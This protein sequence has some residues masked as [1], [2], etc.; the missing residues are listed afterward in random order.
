MENIIASSFADPADVEAFKKWFKIYRDQGM[1]E[2]AATKAAFR[3][4]DNGIGFTGVFCA[5]EAE[6]LCALPP[7]EWKAK[8]GTKK[9]AAGK[10]VIVTYKGKEIPGRLGDTMPAKDKRLND[11]LIDLNPGF[12][13]AFGER[14]PFMLRGV[15]WRWAE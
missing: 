5:T 10:G 9:N 14:P 4:G 3:K 12:A 15:S 6:C 8:W 2:D 11:A 13:K 7:E 1:S